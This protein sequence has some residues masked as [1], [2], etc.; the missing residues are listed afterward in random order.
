MEF[1]DLVNSIAVQ[2]NIE[3]W[4]I[5]EDN[6]DLVFSL[7]NVEDLGLCFYPDNFDEH[8]EVAFVY[9]C[10]GKLIIEVRGAWLPED[11]EE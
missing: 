8:C 1:Y 7:D 11:D 2:G 4:N 3:V 5:C 9:P 10:D 6:Q